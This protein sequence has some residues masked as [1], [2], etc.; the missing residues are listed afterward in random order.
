MGYAYARI[1]CRHVRRS[2]RSELNERCLPTENLLDLSDWDKEYVDGT[3]VPVI[4]GEDEGDPV[5]CVTD[6]LPHLAQKQMDEKAGT[7]I[8]IPG[9]TN[10][11][12]SPLIFV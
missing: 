10:D 8:K 11:I 12:V 9:T 5:F 7:F 6:L 1:N 4:I 3:K 2:R